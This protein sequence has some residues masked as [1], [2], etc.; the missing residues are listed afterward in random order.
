MLRLLRFFLPYVVFAAIISIKEIWV[1]W[2]I[3]CVLWIVLLG[4]GNVSFHELGDKCRSEL[5]VS[6]S[7]VV[8]KYCL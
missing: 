5:E 7:H 1:E 8:L 6:F 4:L 2:T 3:F